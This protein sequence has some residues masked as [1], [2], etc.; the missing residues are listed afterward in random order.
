[1]VK[2]NTN[3]I[4]R[5]TDVIK[6][7][8]NEDSINPIIER[9]TPGLHILLSLNEIFPLKIIRNIRNKNVIKPGIPDSK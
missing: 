2:R 8:V 4:E 5:T 7:A 6:P 1:M 9:K 3:T